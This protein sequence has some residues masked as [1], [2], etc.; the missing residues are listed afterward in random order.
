MLPEA[1]KQSKV[2]KYGFICHLHVEDS[3]ISIL[4]SSLRSDFNVYLS[5]PLGNLTGVS[6]L[7]Q[8][9]RAI[10]SPVPNTFPS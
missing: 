4:G 2:N 3:H 10:D 6:N 7:T 5:T 9:N 8:P 1:M